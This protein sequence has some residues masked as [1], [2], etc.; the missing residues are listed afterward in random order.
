[1]LLQLA[2]VAVLIAVWA[3]R[4]RDVPRWRTALFALGVGLLLVAVVSPLARIGETRLFSIHMT[5]HLLIGDLA[6]LCVAVALDGHRPRRLAHPFLALPL[7]AANLLLWHLPVLYDAALRHEGLHVLQHVLF[8][9][10]GL[11]L[12]SA[13]VGEGPEW[14]GIGW[15]LLYVLGMWLVSLSLAQ[16]F[17]WGGH[18]FYGPYVHAPRIWGTTALGDQRAGGGVMLV[19]GSFV[20]LGAIVWLLLE[21]FRESEERQQA[22]DA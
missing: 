22:L 14:F 11:F 3:L 6:P 15:K 13:I 21:A 2:A 16:V 1:M 10:T 20:M 7:W 5:Q 17:L 8:F 9:C 19:E 12:W 18:A 4:V